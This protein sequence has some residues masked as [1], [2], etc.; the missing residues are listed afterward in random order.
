MAGIIH[1]ITLLLIMLILG[2]YAVYIPMAALSAV[3]INVSW[4]MAGFPAV[5]A[6]L[7]GQ[8]SDIFVL[9]ATFL[10]TVFIDFIQ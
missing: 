3:L 2:K 1:A 10:I 9:A 8:K 6:L 5:K 4:N 7:K